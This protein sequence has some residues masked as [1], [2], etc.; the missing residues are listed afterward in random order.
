VLRWLDAF[1][2]ESLERIVLRSPM[3]QRFVLATHARALRSVLRSVPPVARVTIVGGGLFPRTALILRQLLPEATLTIVDDK[4][5]HIEI[6]RAFLDE[7]AC[8][9][10]AETRRRVAF[11]HELFDPRAP[12][13]AELLVIPLAFIGDR[14]S[15]Y[16]R[17]PAPWT[18]VHDW[19]WNRQASGVP[20][21]LWLL[22]RLNLVAR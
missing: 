19:I 2:L 22:K 21:S 4:R 12:D 5:E 20:V 6:A 14:G 9:A 16:R 3:L 1:S 17:S 10:E 7:S 18:I 13:D 15:L 8:L 11:R